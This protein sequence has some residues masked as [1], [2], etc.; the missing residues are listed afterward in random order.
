MGFGYMSVLWTKMNDKVLLQVTSAMH[1]CNLH[2]GLY[3]GAGDDHEVTQARTLYVFAIAWLF[4]TF[5]YGFWEIL[6]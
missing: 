1:T 2:G 3:V 4:V 5:Y 6:V